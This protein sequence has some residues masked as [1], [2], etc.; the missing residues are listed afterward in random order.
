M[1]S[2]PR[3]RPF[4]AFAA[5]SVCIVAAPIRYG[6]RYTVA[7]LGHGKI[8]AY[9]LDRARETARRYSRK[10]VEIGPPAAFHRR[11]ASP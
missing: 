8:T 11:E 6:W 5:L 2:K 10:V 9:T 3:P 4:P 7:P 1:S